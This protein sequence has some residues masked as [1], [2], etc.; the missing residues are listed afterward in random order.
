MPVPT[1]ID[2]LCHADLLSHRHQQLRELLVMTESILPL[3]QQGE[4]NDALSR[5]R[6][7]RL[8]M[9]AFFEQPCSA[10]E[11][12]LVAKV[13]ERILSIDDQVTAALADKR[14]AMANHQLKQRRQAQNVGSYLSNC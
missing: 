11:A 10:D 4:W 3:A 12:P 5:Q 1:D 2:A 9:E 14:N 8:A 7:R 13:I 6:D